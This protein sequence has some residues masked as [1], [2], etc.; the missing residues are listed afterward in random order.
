[1]KKN[2]KALRSIALGL[3]VSLVGTMQPFP[4]HAARNV[5]ADMQHGRAIEYMEDFEDGNAS[6]WVSAA[7]P[8]QCAVIDGKLDIETMP[9][10]ESV[11]PLF[12]MRVDK[13]SPELS[14]G[15]LSADFEVKSH[16]GRFGFVFHYQDIENY[17]AIGYDLNGTWKYFHCTDGKL[18]EILFDGPEMTKGTTGNI[19]ITFQKG[20]LSVVLDDEEIYQNSN[21]PMHSYGQ[22]AIRTWGYS[23][24]YAHIAV[25][26]IAYNE[27]PAVEYVQEFDTEDISNWI[28]KANGT[29]C[30]V[31]D[32][33][34]DIETLA[35]NENKQPQYALRIDENSPA[36][37]AG[38]LEADF[39][40]RSHA[41]RFAFV[42]HYQDDN[43]FDALGYDING[44]WVYF[45]RANGQTEDVKFTGP[46]M[47][48]GTS[49]N[50][51]IGF[52]DGNL[53]VRLDG[54]T[55]FDE[56][57]IPMH[58]TGKMGIRIWGYS[59]NYAHIA[60]DRISYNE[61]KEVRLTPNDTY[62]KYAQAGTYD[63]TT[64]LS[65]TE[66]PLTGLAVGE[67]M[68]EEGTDYVVNGA[69][70]TLKKEFIE[71]VK[72]DGNTNVRFIF[73]DGYEAVFKLQVQFPPKKM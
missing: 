68:L 16:A 31:I 51:S 15:V 73:E 36:I 72:A 20:K 12:G 46:A 8:T 56:G 50:I 24:N 65:S 41:G 29:R 47:T 42:F 6:N 11:Q 34:L 2:D 4:V 28:S 9:G 26:T 1:M 3:C 55:I 14:T 45:H 5:L 43:N 71:S 62:V 39:D 70:V 38:E 10:N 69:E 32:G 63:V 19:K 53:N 18:D 30:E 33:K 66:N 22:M 17:D 52:F 40:V 35:G 37:S 57:N 49:A 48:Q 61:K 21:A 54:E 27:I 67:R 58:N 7:N 23:E 59:G 25:D 60:L 64:T 13:D 44:T